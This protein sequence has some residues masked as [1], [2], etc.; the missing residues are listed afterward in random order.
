MSIRNLA[1]RVSGATIH[2][3]RLAGAVESLVLAIVTRG[4]TWVSAIPTIILTSRTCQIVFGLGWT[5]ALLSAI[6]LEVVGAA[7]VNTWLS[8]KEWN[9]T[10][11]KSDPR[12]NERMALVAT[13]CYFV[14]DFVLVG[15]VAIPK[16]QVNPVYYAAMLFPLSQVIS[17]LMVSERAAQFR[18]SAEVAQDKAERKAQ[19][20][21]KRQAKRKAQRQ[22]ERLAASEVTSENTILDKLQQGKRQAKESRLD[23]LLTFYLDNPDAGPTEAAGAV[24]VSRQTIYAYQ[25]ELEA[26][27]KLKKNGRG[28]EVAR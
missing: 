5:E 7:V 14:T 6:A 26:Q 20:Q 12:A 10:K 1:D 4:A 22:A 19:R 24:G 9:R 15:I 25:E 2:A 18:R 16:A 13:V 27:G 23:T 28:W 11:R 3:D 8:A 21:A 17:T